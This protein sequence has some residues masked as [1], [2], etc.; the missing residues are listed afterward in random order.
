MD[1][2]LR[3]RIDDAVSKRS[4]S[5]GVAHGEWLDRDIGLPYQTADWLAQRAPRIDRTPNDISNSWRRGFESLSTELRAAEHS[6]P[7]GGPLDELLREI[8]RRGATDVEPAPFEFRPIATPDRAPRETID[9]LFAGAGLAVISPIDRSD[10]MRSML[11]ETQDDAAARLRHGS[12]RREHEVSAKPLDTIAKQLDDLAR[13]VS[14]REGGATDDEIA[15]FKLR[16]TALARETAIEAERKVLDGGGRARGQSNSMFREDEQHLPETVP[17]DHSQHQRFELRVRR[18]DDW[19]DAGQHADAPAVPTDLSQGEAV[20]PDLSFLLDSL[21]RELELEP[22]GQ[23]SDVELREDVE[24]GSLQRE[25]LVAVA[26]ERWL[27]RPG[28]ERDVPAVFDDRREPSAI[29]RDLPSSIPPARSIDPSKKG[30]S[31]PAIA[32]MIRAGLAAVL[33][34]A[35]LV[36]GAYYARS[37]MADL[38]ASGPT[39]TVVY[40]RAPTVEAAAAGPLTIMPANTVA[41]FQDLVFQL[42]R[43]Y[44]IYAINSGRLFELESLPGQA[45]DPRI[46]VSAAIP[47]PSHTTLPDGRVAFLLFRRDMAANIPERV[48]VRVV[49]RFKRSTT[50]P[51]ADQRAAGSED[52]WTIRNIAVDFR[53]APVEHNKEM[54]LLL[55]EKP[56]FTFPSGRY[57]LILKGQAYDFT[58]AGPVTDPVQCLE[59]V[60][61]ANGSFFHECQAPPAAEEPSS[62]DVVPLAAR[63]A[64]KSRRQS[65]L[66]ARAEDQ[67]PKARKPR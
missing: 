1:D 56:D 43:L 64:P 36:P 19:S 13:E 60:E 67:M 24:P 21:G 3:K 66:H 23:S 58:V 61:A 18:D 62:Q 9:E 47:R 2:L 17:D 4:P 8:D 51:A 53:V 40:E 46:A 41:R 38:S 52:A 54:V 32:P 33:A 37:R 35:I 59:R 55:S 39:A 16:L 49:A 65:E 57:A 26:S 30:W 20:E 15:A 14:Q 7:I 29:D 22:Q 28:L 42:P 63:S 34:I 45:P 50:G 10:L 44:G 31:H 27:A 48:S 5:S 6:N 25:Q 11:R 12:E